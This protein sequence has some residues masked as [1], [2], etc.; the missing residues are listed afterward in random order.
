LFQIAT[1]RNLGLQVIKLISLIRY[2]GMSNG[3]RMFFGLL[4][5]NNDQHT[6]NSPYFLNTITLRKAQSDPFIF[7]QVF[8]EQ[9][10]HFI[11]P[12]PEK[13][14]W[15][16]D[17]G[18]NIGLAAIYFSNRYPNAKIL[19]IEPDPSNF[20][21][22]KKNTYDYNNIICLQ[23]AIWHCSEQLD[24]LNKEELSAGYM[25]GTA[26]HNNG[27]LIQGYT[28][29]EL[30]EKYEM[31]DLMVKLDIEGSEKEVMEYGDLS[32]LKKC[33]T[34]VIELHD[35]MKA[36]TSKVYFEKMATY[37]WITYVKG[38]NIISHKSNNS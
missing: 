4:F 6:I 13:V 30:I 25:M 34:L 26:T 11:H 2:Y 24:I 7:E 12:Q 29:N 1:L 28:L 23:G 19:S 5:S 16:I 37:D 14:K 31:T 20:Q 21:L 15:I 17:A 32:W 33:S 10:Y 8:C 9:Q 36:G 3:L 35:W 22:L 38:E 27:S 18:A